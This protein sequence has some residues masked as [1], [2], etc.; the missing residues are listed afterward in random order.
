[1]AKKRLEK[2]LRYFNPAIN[3]GYMY[4]A[5]ARNGTDIETFKQELAKLEK[6]F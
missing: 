2:L 3:A 6:D 4:G 5:A 1:M